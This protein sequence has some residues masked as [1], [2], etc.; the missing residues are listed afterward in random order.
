MAAVFNALLIEIFSE[1]EPL[2]AGNGTQAYKVPR[3]FSILS[4]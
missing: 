2:D 1:D 4:R 3:R